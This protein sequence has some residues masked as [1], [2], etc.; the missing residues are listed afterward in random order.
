M[1]ANKLNLINSI[2]GSNAHRYLIKESYRF[3]ASKGY[4]LEI[5]KKINSG[6]V[7]LFASKG[8][9]K[10]IIE[11]LLRPYV[12]IVKDKI[13][14]YKNSCNRLII[15]YPSNFQSNFP[16]EDYTE[17][18]QIDIP[19]QLEEKK[20]S[21]TVKDS[22]WSILNKKRELGETMDDVICKFIMEADKLKFLPKF[23]NQQMIGQIQD[24]LNSTKS[25]EETNGK[26]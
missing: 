3:F 7:D 4:N 10:I 19:R 23:S 12:T 9:E 26:S 16:I 11:C 1:T 22:T 21:I 6:R 24:N 14:K 2:S 5:E 15:I 8:E 18:M 20:I 13:K 25:K 17:T